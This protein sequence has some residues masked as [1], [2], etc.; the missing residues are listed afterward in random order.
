VSKDTKDGLLEQRQRFESG[1]ERQA[2]NKVR[3]DLISAVALKRL[4]ETYAEGA[5][6]YG[7]RNWEKGQPFSV[8]INHARDHINDF[9]AQQQNLPMNVS[10]EDHLAHAAW[11]LFAIMHFQATKPKMND[12][13]SPYSGEI[14]AGK[15]SANQVTATHP[16][17]HEFQGEIGKRCE[18]CNKPSHDIIHDT[19]G[20]RSTEGE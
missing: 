1:S 14:T 19:T 20:E 12:L 17:A 4:A 9:I 15:I 6:K 2:L 8:L 7:D 18:A 5:T 13:L 11:N 10:E 3:Y 16:E